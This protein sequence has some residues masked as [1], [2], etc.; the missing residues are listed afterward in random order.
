MPYNLLLNGQMGSNYSM[1][2]VQRLV[3]SRLIFD[4]TISP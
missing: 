4:V 3:E 2:N 1:P